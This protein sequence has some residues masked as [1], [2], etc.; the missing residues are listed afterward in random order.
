V[1]TQRERDL[2]RMEEI[3]RLER[4]R[5]AARQRQLE[6]RN[7]KILQDSID[8]ARAERETRMDQDQ[9]RRAKAAED[10]KRGPGRAAD[11]RARGYRQ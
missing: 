2:K 11:R 6:A 5:D 10:R 7:A 3:R 9:A 8:H 4:E 1:E